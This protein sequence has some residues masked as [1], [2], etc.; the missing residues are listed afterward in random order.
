VIRWWPWSIVAA[1]VGWNLVNLRALTLGVTYLN[2]STLHE[3]M[4][5]FATA[6]LRAGH[7]P[8]T[9]WFPFLG[10]GSPQFLHYQ[11]LPAVL[12]GAF[13]LLIGP[14][15]AFRWSLYL[16]LSLWPISVYLSARAF[17]AGRPAAAA[18]A[19]MAPFLVSATWVG[20]EQQAYVWTGFGVW[21][22]LWASWTLPL[23]WGWSWRAIRD[24]RGYLAAVLLTA[25]T[26]ALHFETGY[27]ALSVLLVW[28]L[29][30]GRP[31]V[32]RLRRAA[33][34]LGGSLL[35]AAWVIVPLVEQRRWAA[36][37]EP[38]QGSG[39][40]NGYGARVVVDWLV[41]G[42]LLD[43]GRLPV[44]TVFAALGL[45]LA[46][47]AWSSDADARALLAA[48]A[49]CLLLAFG[50]TTFGSL[51]EVIPGSADLFFRRFMMG[52]QLAALLLAGRGAAWLAAG[53]VRLLKARV[54]RWPR[55]VSAAALLVAAVA[56][57]APGW[58][59]LGAYDRQD[60]AAIAAQRHA[61]ATE[62]AQ[63][64]R[65]IAVIE[66]HGG[67]RTYAGMPSNWGQDF[68]VGAVPVFKYLESRDVDEVGYT[69]RTASLMTDPEYFF[70]DRDPSDYRLFGIR[71][72][73]LPARDQPPVRARLAMRSGPYWLW[74]ID[75]AGYVQVGRIV[76][77]ISANRTNVG[78]R[79]LPLLDSG[80]ADDGAYLSVRYGSGGSGDGRLPTVPSQS[81]AGEVT[82]ERADLDDGEATATLQMRRA[83]VAVLSASYDPGW[84]AIVNGRP[85]PT[86]MVAP[87]LVAVDVPAGTDHVVFR[88]HGYGDYP[89]LLALSGL[90]LALVAAAPVCARR[91][92]RRR[93][94][95]Q[96]LR[97]AEGRADHHEET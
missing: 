29:V 28:P 42:Q 5:R 8:L 38:L 65:L 54:P 71:Y 55:G 47:L 9:S 13:G 82:A 94:T 64:D 88:F 48:F 21:T 57:L 74:T 39:L 70:D 51:V 17:G 18:S 2:D 91:A 90:T 95:E 52:V 75:G 50:R 4:V 16:L 22:Q 41:S 73:I 33:V 58:L 19:A 35:G 85:Q 72:L 23:A 14:D 37:N 31:L 62:G 32:A 25:L 15:V 63:L 84:T 24:G 96:A 12:T 45:A 76:G 34:L 69:L 7:L 3:Q 61:D 40:V 10:E 59:Q 80:L 67:G 68:T 93:E 44:V 92:R 89:E 97:A 56:V 83:G 77:Q 30:A 60:G 20:Y 66:R 87:A 81:S 36:L 11:S 86:E 79:S 6:Q 78:T 26:V 49:V 1:A 46:W 43:H 53:C 27:L